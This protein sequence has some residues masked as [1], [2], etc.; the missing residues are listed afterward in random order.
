MGTVLPNFPASPISEVQPFT[1]RDNESY[2]KQLH[3]LRDYVR[4]NLQ[5]LNNQE[6]VD[7]AALRD[8]LNTLSDT[9]DAKIVE[10]ETTVNGDISTF[11][12]TING[13]IST[14]ETAVNADLAGYVIQLNAAIATANSAKTEADAA[15][16]S[17]D[18]AT[19]QNINT[20][21]LTQVAGD[22]RWIPKGAQTVSVK[23]YGAVGD[24]VTDDS[25]AIA[26]ASAAAGIGGK[27]IL[28]LGVN[29]KGRYYCASPITLLDYQTLEGTSG[30]VTRNTTPSVELYFPNL[31]TGNAVTLGLECTLRNIQLRG[32]GSSVS[33]VTGIYCN[34][35]GVTFD[36]VCVMSFGT[37]ISLKNVYYSVFERCG[38]ISNGIGLL[39]SNCYNVNLN[40]PRF[41]CMNE[42]RP[43]T[44]N[45]IGI[46]LD[47][48]HPL[49]IN[50]GSI[51][52]YSSGGGIYVTAG[53]A[54]IS[55]I[56]TY[57]ES[58]AVGAP[59]IGI[60]VNGLPSVQVNALCN[61]VYLTNAN[62][63][64]NAGASSTAK[65]VSKGNKFVCPT[66]STTNPIAYNI[67]PGYVSGEIGPDD[68]KDVAKTTAVYTS[69]TGVY[70]GMTIEPP[71]DYPGMF[72]NVSLRGRSLVQPQTTVTGNYTVQ[73]T[74]SVII[75]KSATAATITLPDE[76][77]LVAGR[78]FTVKNAGAG[79]CS[80][81]SATGRL[82]DGIATQTLNQYGC[83]VLE[84]RPADGAY[85]II[86]K[87]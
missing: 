15:V 66:T 48:V 65:I 41:A 83:I 13:E 9:L 85:S 17:Q 61:F 4:I 87:I 84:D 67:T 76:T 69:S 23:D 71:V 86:S 81:T 38:W 21:P 62:T 78:R 14:F 45:G 70:K 79:V 47:A 12:T 36:Y 3:R 26:S 40:N 72:Q 74:D 28:P 73:D 16:A 64:L 80:V 10:F 1:Y 59:P 2:L 82:I 6:I 19:A 60:Q 35:N 30:A 46:Q 31:T 53:T 7:V 5:R 33:T 34:N 56:G 44:A 37:G 25:A 75:V 29:Q 58:S 43:V 42:Q 57:W 55:C 54:D 68:W 27:I 63:W 18:S 22:A 39:L 11:E 24:G 8:D 50:G 52:E 49:I 20:G 77:T 32:A 51:E